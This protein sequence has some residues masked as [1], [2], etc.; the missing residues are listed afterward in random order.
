M[1]KAGTLVGTREYINFTE[2]SGIVITVTDDANGVIV[3]IAAS[4]GGAAT[5]TVQE[6]GVTVDASVSVVDFR[7]GFDLTN[8]SA[9]T[10]RVNL[11]LSE[12]V[13]GD[14]T[15]TTNA[16]KVVAIQNKDIAAPT[17]A[18]NQKAVVYSD[19]AGD[20]IYVNREAFVLGLWSRS[21]I[22]TGAGSEMRQVGA[23]GNNIDVGFVPA[24]DGYV[25]GLSV[26]ADG[27]VGGVGDAYVI[28][29][30]KNGLNTLA[31]LSLT[32]SAGTDTKAHTVTGGGALP[33]SFSGG[34]VITLYDGET[35]SLSARAARAFIHGYY[36]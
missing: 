6:G 15:Y 2:G 30:Y 25:T 1:K 8:P 29:L 33:V 32:G 3:D 4:G 17:S 21:D 11:D 16:G 35:G 34:D 19:S 13:T 18:E 23:S 10:V 7:D 36:V 26:V 28:T 20:F 12:V 24:R 14:V 27:D 22:S 5:I 9:G 31:Q